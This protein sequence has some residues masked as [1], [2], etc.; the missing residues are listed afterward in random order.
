MKNVSLQHSDWDQC[1]S[2]EH[3]KCVCVCVSSAARLFRSLSKPAGEDVQSEGIL[4]CFLMWELSDS[5]GYLANFY[6]RVPASLRESFSQ[7]LLCESGLKNMP[8]HRLSFYR[9]QAGCGRDRRLVLVTPST[10]RRSRPWR[11]CHGAEQIVAHV[12]VEQ[13]VAHM[14]SRALWVCIAHKIT[15]WVSLT[16]SDTPCDIQMCEC[17]KV[18]AKSVS[19]GLG[20]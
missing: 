4:K 5:G 12:C 14:S 13:T 10:S 19:K 3:L 17:V 11:V 7:V 20:V 6:A 16:W 8:F 18:M 15:C 2:S 9:L 1:L